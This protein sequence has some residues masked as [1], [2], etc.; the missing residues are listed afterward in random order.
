MIRNNHR[1]CSV[2][3]EKADETLFD[4]GGFGVLNQDEAHVTSPHALRDQHACREGRALP[5]GPL[6]L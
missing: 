6:V 4:A 5:P 3:N 1:G 2:A